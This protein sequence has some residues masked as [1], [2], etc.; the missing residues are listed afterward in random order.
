[1]YTKNFKLG[2]ILI[3]KITSQKTTIK[4]EN[5]YVSYDSSFSF[6]VLLVNPHPWI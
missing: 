1:M 2:Y 4:A 6:F 5:F 3:Y